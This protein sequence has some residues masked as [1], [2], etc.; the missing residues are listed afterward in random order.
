VTGKNCF[1]ALAVVALMLVVVGC[2]GSRADSET[3]DSETTADAVPHVVVRVRAAE[4]L[5]V[6]REVSAL[7][8]CEALPEKLA[9][10]TPA[11]EGQVESI[12]ATQGQ[13]VAAGQPIVQ[14]DL[15]L[16]KADLAEKQAAR[17]SLTAS[18]A[19]LESRPRTAEQQASKLAI[20]QA[21]IAVAR[22]A[23]LVE[24]LR[25]L[26][27]NAEI[28]EQQL[29]E[30]EQS[31][32]QAQVQQQSAEAQ[33][34]A[35]MLSPRPEAVAEARSKIKVAEEAVK[36]SQARL[37]L[38]TIRAPIEGVL[39]RLTCRLG[40][41]IAI[42]ATL[43]EVVD[44]RQVLA[45]AWMPVSRSHLVRVGQT[46]QIQVAVPRSA[47]ASPD[48][49]PTTIA[50]SVI[51]VG[52]IADVQ[53]GNMPVQVLADNSRGDLVVGQTLNMAILVEQPT[54]TLAVPVA[55]IHD[56]GEGSVIT[57]VRDGKAVLLH[58]QLGATQTGWIA[59]SDT[60]LKEGEPVIVEGG[61]NLPE[62]TAVTTETASP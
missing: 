30:A 52:R 2:A 58:P 1:A 40:Q 36:L 19:L 9:L 57:V 8:R 28:S 3:P 59:V 32:K 12:L 14:F 60:D 11:V 43:G 56:E 33:F 37:D 20:E 54:P 31:L 23:A 49:T 55:A 7:G 42:G 46:V 45:V 22:A 4:Q 21:K 44:N 48:A 61:Y 15:T 13:H 38:H 27:A 29:Y 16:A 34:K 18:L 62:G 39:D 17:D 25:P 53:T 6:G 51:F 5:S 10:L 47:T 41:T 35:L 50:G 24:R 26:R